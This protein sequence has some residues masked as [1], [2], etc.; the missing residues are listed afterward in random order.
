MLKVSNRPT[1]KVGIS[2]IS[3]QCERVTQANMHLTLPNGRST[4]APCSNNNLDTSKSPFLL[5]MCRDESPSYKYKTRVVKRTLF[6]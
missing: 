2:I 1:P 5:E 6:H 4:R 3:I